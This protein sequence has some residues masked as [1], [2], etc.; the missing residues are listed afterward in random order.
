MMCDYAFVVPGKVCQYKII[1]IKYNRSLQ[2]YCNSRLY[3]TESL[4]LI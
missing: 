1:R 2:W 3:F 4:M